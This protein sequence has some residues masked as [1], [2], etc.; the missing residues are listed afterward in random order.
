MDRHPNQQHI[1]AT[2]GQ[3]GMLCVWDVRQGNAPFSLMEAHT[4]ESK[5]SLWADVLITQILT[6]K[7]KSKMLLCLIFLLFAILYTFYLGFPAQCGKSTSIQPTQTICSH[8]QRTAHCCTGRL[9]HI[10][11]CLPSYK[12]NLDNSVCSLV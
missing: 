7:I 1:V 8:A 12:V 4:A 5:N 11:T 9:L 10:Q 2:G 6:R 3:D